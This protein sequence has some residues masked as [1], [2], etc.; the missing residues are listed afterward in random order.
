M[1]WIQ[2]AGMQ[3]RLDAIGNVLERHEGET[4]DAPTLLLGSHVDTVHNARRFDG[5]LGG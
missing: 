2:A 4:P 5:S 1:G 3:S